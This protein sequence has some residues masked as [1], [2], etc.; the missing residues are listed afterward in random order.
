MT[1]LER[2]GA[3]VLTLFVVAVMIFVMLGGLR[4]LLFRKVR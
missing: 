1:G 3:V 4:W 2:R